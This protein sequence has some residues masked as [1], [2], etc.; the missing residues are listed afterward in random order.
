MTITEFLLARI[1]EDETAARAALIEAD[2]FQF[3]D[4]AA[5]ALLGLSES[6]GAQDEAL[7]HFRRHDPARVLAACEAKR[8]IVKAA[9][10]VADLERDFGEHAGWSP[11]DFEQV[12]SDEILRGLASEYADHPD[13]D[14]KWSV[15]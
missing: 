14:P 1:A 7:A 3:G 13:F 11:D 5:E 6:E 10:E 4:T 15:S 9:S 2:Y 8:R 12:H